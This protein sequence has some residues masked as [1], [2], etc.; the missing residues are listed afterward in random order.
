[1]NTNKINWKKAIVAGVLGTILFDIVGWLMTGNFWDIPSLLGEK[2][3]T[4]CR[5]LSTR[6]PVPSA[7]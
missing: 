4:P 2:T 6:S 3:E 7:G 5:D 1:M